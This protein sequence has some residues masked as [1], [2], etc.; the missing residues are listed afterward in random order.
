MDSG[1]EIPMLNEQWEFAGCR[2]FEWVSGVMLLL[3]I[4][5]VSGKA[6]P[7]MVPV[8]ITVAIVAAKIFATL[9]KRFPDE[10]RGVRNFFMVSMGFAPPFIPTPAA[11][12]PNW[13][14]GRLKSLKETTRFKELGLDDI[15]EIHTEDLSEDEVNA[16]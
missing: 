1:E 5:S 9:R 12:Q 14:G 11:L 4:F 7:M 8:G 2:L 13:S 10:E 6:A 16:L 3:L 15:F